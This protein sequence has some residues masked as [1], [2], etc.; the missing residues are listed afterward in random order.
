MNARDDLLRAHV[1]RAH[2]LRGTPAIR[3][4]VL[5]AV[6][7]WTLY[8]AVEAQLALERARAQAVA[9]VFDEDA[10]YASLSVLD[11]NRPPRPPGWRHP[12]AD[13]LEAWHRE[14]VVLMRSTYPREMAVAA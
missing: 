10:W 13:D 8:P 1:Y 14:G 12:G 3:E 2:A 5:D 9:H 11:E 4:A 7:G 6:D